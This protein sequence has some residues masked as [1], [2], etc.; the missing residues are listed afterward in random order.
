MSIA[1]GLNEAGKH[2]L[3]PLPKPKPNVLYYVSVDV[4]VEAK[5]ATDAEEKVEGI[6]DHITALHKGYDITDSGECQS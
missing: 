4:Y 1:D 5:N 2:Y 6:I 3:K